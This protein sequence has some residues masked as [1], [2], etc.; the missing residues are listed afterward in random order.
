MK[1]LYRLIFAMLITGIP[2]PAA[3]AKSPG[4]PITPGIADECLKFYRTEALIGAIIGKMTMREKIAQMI[5]TDFGGWRWAELEEYLGTNPLGGMI[6]M[7]AYI[8]GCDY[9]KLKA[10]LAK[11]QGLSP[12]IPVLVCVD[13]EGGLVQRLK[14]IIGNYPSPAKTYETKGADGIRQLAEE[15]AQKLS[16]LGIQVDFAPVVDSINNNASVVVKRTFTKDGATNAMLGNIF[17]ETF[18][19]YGMIAAAKHYPGYGTVGVDPHYFTCKD[20]SGKIEEVGF[21]FF[22]MTNC[23]MIMTSHVIFSLYDNEP[24]TLSP[25]VLALLRETFQGVIITDDLRMGSITALHGYRDA[26]LLA[27]KAGCD[28]ILLIT[29]GLESWKKNADT[30]I[31]FLMTGY[32]NG[33]LSDAEIDEKVA[34]ILRLKLSS[35]TDGKWGILDKTELDEYKKLFPSE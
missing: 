13:Q 23:R 11:L 19:K 7:G 18:D 35:L 5:F 17:I 9:Q 22:A 21:P 20:A 6:L 15:F 34:R 26:A 12:K 10:N 25:A 33:V 3:E 29:P 2:F 1:K 14:T 16:G 31:D 30:M 24:A 4:Y 8:K 32:T 27:L 28:A